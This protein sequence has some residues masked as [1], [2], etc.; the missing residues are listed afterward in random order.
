MLVNGYTVYDRHNRPS[1][2]QP[3][4]LR[5]FFINNGQFQDPY[6]IS[7]VTVFALSDNTSPSTVLTSAN[8]LNP[9]VASAVVKMGFANSAQL[10]S[11]VAF[12]ASNYTPGATASGIYKLSVGEYIAVLNG[13]VALSGAYEG[14]KIPNRASGVGDYIDIWTVRWVQNSDWEI[15]VNDFRLYRDTIFTATEPLLVTTTNKLSNKHIKLG[16]K[17]DLKIATE[18]NIANKNITRSIKNTFEDAAITSAQVQIVKL[19]D[20]YT[21][22]ARVT[23]SSF[24]N[25]SASVDVTSDNTIVFNW[26][27]NDLYTLPAVTAGTFGPL[28]G[29]YCVQVKYGILNQTIVS[30]LMYVIVD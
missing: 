16:S 8:L 23:V 14:T 3:V 4:G 17:V 21:L 7:S 20:D 15:F 26:D 5:A 13:Q 27:T 2:L 9:S 30:D 11:N 22:P 18:V 24:A 29:T 25:T 12:N 10:I 1:V 28:T 19:N 6:E